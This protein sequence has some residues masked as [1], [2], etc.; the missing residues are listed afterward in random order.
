MKNMDI[1]DESKNTNNMF[2]RA[3]G[4]ENRF[5]TLEVPNC[6]FHIYN[7]DDGTEV[8]TTDAQSDWSAYG[9]FTWP[10]L[11]SATQTKMAYGMLFT[12][13]YTGAVSAYSLDDGS[14]IWR[15]SYP[16][17]GAKIQNYVQML[18]MIADGK[19]FVGTHEHSADTPLYKGERVHALNVTTGE[20]IWDMSG[21]V[22]PMTMAVA[23]GIMVYWNNY[24]AQVY[25]IGKGPTQT[26]VSAPGAGVTMG[27]S[28]TITG[29]VNDI[30]AGTKQQEQAARF[31][32]GV[33]AVNEASQAQWME[34]VYMQKAKPTNTTGVNVD[35]YVVDANMNYRQIGTTTTTDGFFSFNWKPDIE[36]AFTVYASFAGSESYWP[37]QAITAFTV[38]PAA[39]TPTPA[40]V[41]ESVADQYFV[42]AIAGLFIAVI[43]V[44]VLLA[45]LL[46]RKHP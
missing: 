40:P 10:S 39:A 46:L 21:W 44:G 1:D 33:P 29:T 17:G 37:S 3:T 34:Y 11:I 30:S 35:L 41:H 27:N 16:S 19:I 13:G 32:N 28:V 24:D 18:G 6:V 25:A 9:Y 12:G 8:G 45:V 42:P 36:G 7:I 31:P 5:V 20:M 14:L 15:Q 4:A 23:D 26:T 43:L 2:E 22:Y 38:D